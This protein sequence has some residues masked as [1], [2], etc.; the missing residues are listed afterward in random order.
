MIRVC[1]FCG[2]EFE[3]QKRR[4][5]CSEQCYKSL[6]AQKM[7]EWRQNKM[8]PE[9]EQAR[10]AKI[11]QTKLERYGDKNYNNM[12]KNKNTKL[13]RYGDKNYN[14][15]ELFKETYSKKKPEEVQAML[16]K[17]KQTNLERY[18]NEYYRNMEKVKETVS[19]KTPSEWRKIITKRKETSLQKYEISNPAQSHFKNKENFNLKFVLKTFVK[20]SKFLKDEFCE[21]FGCDFQAAS[22]FKRR[23]N[24]N[25]PNKNMRS[26]TQRR[27]FDSIRTDDK[28][29]NHRK[30][31]F[32]LELD[33]YIPSAKLAIEYNGLLYHSR[34][35]DSSSKANSPD[36]PR[37]Y[38]LN[39]TK[40]CEE[41]GVQLLHIFE[42]E[43]L[44]IWYSMIHSKLG[45]NEKLY[46]RKCF[47]KEIQFK[48]ASEFLE[49][50]HLQGSCNSKINLGLFYND[51]L[52]SL[53]TFGKAR[54]NKQYDWELLRFCSKRN[55]NVIGAAGKLLKHFR[56]NYNGSIISYA[57]RRWSNGDLY[58][59]LG[60]S[61]VK[62][63]PPNYWYF[64]KNEGVLF[65]RVMFQKHK[66]KD[67]LENFDA[68]LSETQNML[69]NGYRQIFDCGNLVY[70][71]E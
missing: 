13:E 14:N 31:I 70:V 56:R 26:K 1:E 55:L 47:I 38:H 29:E 40:L 41:Q 52:V 49:A 17:Q 19:K 21:Y 71:L 20:N 25:I 69:N 43:N 11:A 45:L 42:G 30:L 24:L 16:D 60:F 39:K 36:F 51:E 66:L 53:M 18:G 4:K 27:I 35:Y 46:A 2:K 23:Y 7:K 44:N 9:M 10:V 59:K 32:P 62:E 63:T 48:E 50:N 5:T 34:G 37:D 61:K 15:R 67:I 22:R 65:S 6:F 12:D 58:E 57:N 33:I 28:L 8:T 68:S 54:F 64:R 3:T